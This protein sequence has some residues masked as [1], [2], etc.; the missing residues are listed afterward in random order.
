M[1]RDVS[2]LRIAVLMIDGID[3]KG[4]TKR[5]GRDRWRQKP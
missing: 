3:L 1:S 5:A 2:G 4:R